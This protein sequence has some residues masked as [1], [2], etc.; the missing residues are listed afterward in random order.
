MPPYI[1][2]KNSPFLSPFFKKIFPW[3]FWDIM[4][5]LLLQRLRFCSIIKNSIIIGY[6]GF[7]RPK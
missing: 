1:S 5:I 4:M 2:R 7:C 6:Y 3:I